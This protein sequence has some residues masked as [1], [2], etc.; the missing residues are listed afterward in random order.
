V[1][2][3]NVLALSNAYWGDYSSSRQDTGLDVATAA[4]VT[5]GHMSWSEVNSTLEEYVARG[6]PVEKLVLGL[7]TSGVTYGG[8]TKNAAGEAATGEYFHCLMQQAIFRYTIV[9]CSKLV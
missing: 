7:V 4:I 1:D 3:F 5:E 6:V 9:S 2:F 8:V